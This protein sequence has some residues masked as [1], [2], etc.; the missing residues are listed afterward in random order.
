MLKLNL[1]WES[2][3][4]LLGDVGEKFLLGGFRTSNASKACPV[5]W[6]L[7]LMFGIGALRSMP[8]SKEQKIQSMEV[9]ER[10]SLIHI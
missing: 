8:M 2:K 7:A 4:L 1:S 5:Q 9:M 10:L 6:W 3:E